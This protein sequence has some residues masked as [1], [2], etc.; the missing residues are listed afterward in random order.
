MAPYPF[1]KALITVKDATDLS[2]TFTELTVVAPV[3]TELMSANCY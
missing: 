2:V 3:S 1:Q